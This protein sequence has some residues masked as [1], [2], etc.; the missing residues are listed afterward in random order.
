VWLKIGGEITPGCNNSEERWA[1]IS[2]GNRAIERRR[3]EREKSGGASEDDNE[4]EEETGRE[5]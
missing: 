3:E 1:I 5:R 2:R 4:K